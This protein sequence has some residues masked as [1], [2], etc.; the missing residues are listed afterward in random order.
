[1][2]VSFRLTVCVC[3]FVSVDLLPGPAGSLQLLHDGRAASLSSDLV[4]DTRLDLVGYA[5]A[6]G[7]QTG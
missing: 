7:T 2:S 4:R 3:V 6:R 1:M 5:V